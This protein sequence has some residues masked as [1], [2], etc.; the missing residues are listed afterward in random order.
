MRCL[1]C[2][3]KIGLIRSITDREYCS[4]VHRKRMRTV[5]A[6]VVRNTLD[7]DDLSEIWP[8]HVRPMDEPMDKNPAQANQ[9]STVI[10]GLVIV[11]ALAVGSMG[12][13]GPGASV[14]MKNSTGPFDDIRKSI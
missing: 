10:F 7:A 14:R 5:S 11:G 3:K 9:A 12:L 1:Y 8:V 13:V 4:R 2:Q 6:R